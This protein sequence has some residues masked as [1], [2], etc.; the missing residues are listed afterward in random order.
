MVAE[1]EPFGFGEEV[2]MLFCEKSYKLD[3]EQR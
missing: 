2:A 3:G 1:V